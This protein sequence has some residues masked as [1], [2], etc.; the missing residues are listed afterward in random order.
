MGQH[1]GELAKIRG[2]VTYKLSPFEQKAFAGVIKKGVP[3]T[4]RRIAENFW[5][6][7]PPFFASYLIYT[8]TEKR[9]E[10]LMRKN[11]EDFACDV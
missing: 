3:N 1:F 6:V 5:R 11:P 7:V 2:L 9:H 8:E 4:L 10:Q